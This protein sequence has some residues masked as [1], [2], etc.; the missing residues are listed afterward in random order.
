MNALPVMVRSAIGLAGILLLAGCSGPQSALM[1]RGRGADDLAALFWWMTAGAVVIWTG[2]LALAFWAYKVHP[3]TGGRRTAMM[4]VG[5]GAVFPTVVLA[6]LLFYGLSMMPPL[7]ASAPDGTLRVFVT[8]EQW[9]W[10]VRYFPAGGAPVD[11]ANEIRLPVDEPVEFH[12]ESSDVI[13]SFWIPN[14]GGKMDMI[15]GRRTRLVLHPTATGTYRGQCAEYCGTSHALMAFPVVVMEKEDFARW[16]EEQRAPARDDPSKGRELFFANGCP[17]C[18]TI[19]GTSADGLVGPDLTHVGSRLTLGAGIIPNRS[20]EFA[21]WIERTDAVK[22]GV[23]MP[24]FGMLPRE[25]LAAVAA[26]LESL[27]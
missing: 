11:L 21:R 3:D 5:G 12:L 19:R 25:E 20:S 23:H 18:H 7:L 24:S 22:P 26:Y 15:P 9:W 14:I 17:A 6:A 16:L 1:P 2:V 13:H 4:I 27:E 10:R 8:G